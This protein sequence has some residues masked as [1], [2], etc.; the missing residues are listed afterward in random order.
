MI[1]HFVTEIGGIEVWGM[2]SI[3]L[4]FTI[5]IGAFIWACCQKK[6]FLNQ[7]SS[8]PLNDGDAPDKKGVSHE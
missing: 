5:F 4:F 2:I 1:K 7:M 8:L 3:C 6:S